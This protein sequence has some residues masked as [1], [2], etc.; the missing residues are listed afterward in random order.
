MLSAERWQ[1]WEEFGCS[2]HNRRELGFYGLYCSPVNSVI[3]AIFYLNPAGRFLD[4]FVLMLYCV[5]RHIVCY[6]SL[7]WPL[8]EGAR[9]L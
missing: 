8:S 3:T 4:I 7:I 5:Y 1:L 6:I 9:P 2:V